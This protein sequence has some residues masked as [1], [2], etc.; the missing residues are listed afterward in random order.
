[1]QHCGEAAQTF[2]AQGSS[3]ALTLRGTVSV[4]RQ[5]VCAQF[6]QGPQSPGQLLQVSEPV[7]L[8]SPHLPQSCGQE[9]GSSL[10]MPS[11][12]NGPVDDELDEELQLAVELA[13]VEDD[14]AE[15]LDAWAL[16]VS[17]S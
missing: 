1:M 15:L 6:V 9:L 16:D 13:L 10:Q 12:Q 7:H 3:H 14:V 17:A 8:P 11:P 4:T 5:T 2:S